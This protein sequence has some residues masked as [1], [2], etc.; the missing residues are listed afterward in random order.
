MK[1]IVFFVLFLAAVVNAQEKILQDGN[2][3]YL[4]NTL[5]VKL[6]ENAEPQNVFEKISPKLSVQKFEK[7]FKDEKPALH[8]GSSG[9]ERIYVMEFLRDENPVTAAK[10]LK[11]LQEVEWVEPK[12]VRQVVYTPNDPK[13]IKDKAD[14][15]KQTNLKR[16]LAEQAW[17]ITK[18]D[19]SVVIGIVDTGVDWTHPDLSA[20]IFRD[21]NGKLVGYDFGGSNGTAD[22]DPIEDQ[23]TT[24]FTGY[25]GTHVAGIAS[26]VTDNNKGI[27]SIGF[28]CSILP[29]K[30]SRGDRRD[31]ANNPYIFYG[32][33]GI[34]YAADNGAKVINCSWGG[35]SYS[36]FEQ[37]TIDYAIS[38]G[39]LVISSAGNNGVSIPFYPAS[40]KGVLSVGWLSTDTEDNVGNYGLYVDVT[41]PG[42][43]IYSSWPSFVTQ[44]D[45]PYIAISGSSMSAPLVSGLAG[46]VFT[47]FPHYTPLQAAER[48][49]VSCDDV[50]GIN[51][52]SLKFLLGRG[53]INAYNALKD[54]AF[55]SVRG[56]EINFVEHGS[57]NGILQ[58]GE[59]A[60]I[61]ITFTNFLQKINGGS[62]QLIID[63]PSATVKTSVIQLPALDTLQTFT[64]S[65]FEFEIAAN[66]PYNHSLKMRLEISADNYSDFQWFETRINQTYDTHN[67]GRITM[68][69]TSKG[70][71]GFNDYF[72][73]QE[74]SGFRYT[75]G[76]NQMFEGAFM[77]GT[78]AER[79]MDVARIS[80]SQSTDFQ[81]VEP[82]KITNDGTAADQVG[83]TIFNDNGSGASSLGITTNFYSYSFSSSPDDGYI[84]LRTELV[85][86]TQ[87]NI[88]NLYAGYFIDWDMPESDYSHDITV[89]D[90][91]DNFGYAYN[92][93]STNLYAGTALISSNSYGYYPIDNAS[94]TGLLANGFSDADKWFTLSNGITN[95]F[96]DTT[97]ISYIISGGPFNIPAGGKTNVAFAIAAGV[98]L[99]ELKNAIKQS[100]I[101]Y[102]L[103]TDVENETTQL[104][105]EFVLKQNYPNPFN[106]ATTIEYVI[107]GVETGYIPSLQQVTLKIY[108]ILG[109]EIATLVNEQQLPGKHSVEFRTQPARQGGNAELSSGI[110]FYR[111]SVGKYAATR[112]MILLK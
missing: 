14:T 67:S 36:R 91:E 72:D 30:A 53:R 65:A 56:T 26:A 93:I 29:V 48:I 69:V 37:E 82:V 104:P 17:D 101:K 10:R 70:A 96:N 62:V 79:L 111:L 98:S 46:L 68:S 102:Q 90:S 97:D 61:E 8:K 44:I 43:S 71:L 11:Q 31:F 89:Y 12:Y 6:K 83:F 25:H 112:K 74:G 106:P 75:S 27:A 16:I 52:D 28:N 15:N 86:S 4:S 39:A 32:Y 41:A 59:T 13:F 20:N 84:I 63:D 22:D 92:A 45:S 77:Y 107:P 50:Y 57:G 49:R 33:E 19:S 109:R 99:D 73:N 34:K 35:Y 54:T 94:A 66:A 38:K 55:T 18:G 76:E 100:R 23:T 1:R 47:K 87:Q 58:S 7:I 103:I 95:G 51:P 60:N 78:S 40:Y 81:I 24:S 9:I 42:S 2:T 21:A 85:N 108:D 110:Y 88:D 64:T 105:N 3:F 80:S 5:V